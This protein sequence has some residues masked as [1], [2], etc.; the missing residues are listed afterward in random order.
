[1]IAA[2]LLL[3]AQEQ[4]LEVDTSFQGTPEE[5]MQAVARLSGDEPERAA[6][7]AE[8]FAEDARWPEA[9]RAEFRYAQGVVR[10]GAGAHGP[11]V[12]AFASARAL[13]GPGELRV[14]ATYNQGTAELL[15][16]E[17]KRLETFKALQDP[18]GAGAA[19]QGS[20]ADPL[21]VLRQAYLGA[22]ATLV[23]RLRADFADPDTRANLEL[24]QRRLRELDE[25][26]RQKEEQEQQQQDQQQ[27]G[28]QDQQGDKGDEQKP[29]EGD[30]PEDPGKEDKPGDKGEKQD[31]EAGQPPPSPADDPNAADPANQGEQQPSG[32]EER[33]AAA[34]EG[35]GEP[36][37]RVL[38]RE[39]VL[40]LLDKLDAIDDEA[41]ALQ[42]LL[43]AS[44]RVPVD[45][46]W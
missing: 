30:K 21:A 5:A 17:E 44:R 39:Q 24:I 3:L 33:E 40:R 34:N 2:L 8:S 13:A 45:K 14:A 9:L 6:A 31:G 16:A 36:A 26:E 29:D 25:L 11:A 20:G 42:A 46:D 35:Q 41:A 18:A 19:A 15:A 4:A 10:D 12:Q 22:R 1:M 7:L 32:A 28:D 27:K 23:E 43:R 37:E 38:S